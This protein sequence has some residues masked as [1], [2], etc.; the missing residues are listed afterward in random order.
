MYADYTYKR[1]QN[2]AFQIVFLFKNFPCRNNRKNISE[3][4]AEK[5]AFNISKPAAKRKYGQIEKTG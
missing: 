1:S 4:K 5:S 3:Y 2:N